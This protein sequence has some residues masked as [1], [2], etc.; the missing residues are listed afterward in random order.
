MDHP[1]RAARYNSQKSRKPLTDA[2]SRANA[3]TPPSRNTKVASQHGYAQQHL[4]HNESILPQGNTL[5]VHHPGATVENKHLSNVVKGDGRATNRDSTIST[6]STHASSSSRRKT[7]I[8][9]WQLGKTIGEGGCSRVRAVRH[10]VTGQLG[11][12]KIISKKTADKVKAQSLLNLYK[13]AETDPKLAAHMKAMPFGLEREIVIMKLLN[14]SNI[15]KLFDVWENRSEL[16]LIMEYVEGG[17]LFGYID[18]NVGLPEMETVYI[19]RQIVAALLYCHRIKI[20]HRDLKPENILID[21]ENLTIK[22]VDFGMAALQPEGRWLSTPCGSPHYAAPEVIRYKQYDGGQ[23]DVWSCGVILYVMLTG[24]PPFTYNDRQDLTH[25]FKIIAQARYVM[26]DGLSEEAQDLI[27]KI[28]VPDPRRRINIEGVWKHPFLHKYDAEFGFDEETDKDIWN[29]PKPRISHWD[30]RYQEDLDRETLRNMRC[31]WHSE[32]EDT[33][34]RKLLNHEANQEKFFYNS[35]QKYKDQQLEHW[36]GEPEISYSASDYHHLARPSQPPPVPHGRTK[37]QYSILNDEHLQAANSFQQP[38]PSEQSYDP[39]RA[40]R[41]PSLAN[42]GNY[43]NV[44]VHRGSTAASGHSSGHRKRRSS[45]ALSSNHG[46]GSSLR[47][48]TL[49]KSGC[50]HSGLPIIDS[51]GSSRRGSVVSPAA[52]HRKSLSKSST[53]S[54][55]WASSP[56]IVVRPSSSHKRG[57]SFAH[58]RRSST[59]SRLTVTEATSA[60]GT[61]EQRK[62]PQEAATQ[63]QQQEPIPALPSTPVQ[64]STPPAPSS[65]VLKSNKHRIKVKAPETPGRAIDGEVRKASVE[66]EKALDEAFNRTSVSSSV[67]TSSERPTPYEY[68]TPPS[69]VSY[70]GSGA[71]AYTA[72]AQALRQTDT[73]RPLPPLPPEATHDSP[74]TYLARELAETRERLAARFALEGGENIANYNEV[75]QSLD[76]LLHPS[77]PTSADANQRSV[78]A[79]QQSP[80]HPRLLPIISE[81]GKSTPDASPHVGT[82][83]WR[84]ATRA[85]TDPVTQAHDKYYGNQTIRIVDASSPAATG[86]HVQPLNIRKKSSGSTLAQAA[87][88]A[89]PTPTRPYHVDSFSPAT[90]S[91]VPPLS[92]KPSL[93]IEIDQTP[94][95]FVHRD[96]L[97]AATQTTPLQTPVSAS[98]TSTTAKD[99]KITKKRSWFKRRVSDRDQTEQQNPGDYARRPRIPEAWQGLDDRLDRPK[100]R[101]FSSYTKQDRKPSTGSTSSNSEFPLRDSEKE[102]I[103]KLAGL[104]KNLASLFG[105]RVP[106]KKS[107]GSL[108]LMPS[109]YS[110]SSLPSSAFSFGDDFDPSVPRYT[111]GQ[112]WLSRFLHIKPATRVIVFQVGRGRVRQE[113]VRLLRDWKRFGVRDV[114]F[115][116]STNIIQA[117]VDKTNRE[118]HLPAKAPA[119]LK[120]Y[121]EILANTSLCANSGIP[122]PELQMKPVA[123][124]AELFTVLQQGRRAQLCVGRFTQTRGAA[125]SFRKVVDILEDVLKGKGII[126][127]DEARAREVAAILGG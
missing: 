56:P 69:S 80:Q 7:H 78:S 105:K 21:A 73:Q 57:V 83:N 68:E 110:A 101:A 86:P 64:A 81:E 18:E 127:E 8:G 126:I 6:A 62:H 58:L 98:S 112:N 46:R 61:P 26:P 88:S 2:T 99:E 95:P 74:N 70:R 63:K 30:L 40:S 123:F 38:P 89:T 85:A 41:E 28:L 103:D 14:H 52:R 59:G 1:G 121:Y 13:S 75:L 106:E 33:I 92:H 109:N 76:R 93:T 77:R 119:K 22:L 55:V 17:E 116:R 90:P 107:R 50:R 10:S 9:P 37:S 115:D 100:P 108:M 47:V 72:D 5:T 125:S 113:I 124:T 91:P 66:L 31:L 12:A 19:F 36:P 3:S 23:A 84:S 53:N 49:K 27:S 16:Y 102:K 45:V 122:H 11:A 39:F 65:A 29:G 104:R 15:V 20:H 60:Q 71:S 117:R 54:S 51:R 111:E 24:Q 32:S 97:D 87:A 114:K 42:K 94:S 43:M 82:P 79:P 25:L 48:D 118:Y 96:S 35:L 67:R 34:V 44:T 4:P 120:G